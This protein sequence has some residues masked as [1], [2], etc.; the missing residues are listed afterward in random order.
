MLRSNNLAQLHSTRSWHPPTHSWHPF[1][2]KGWTWQPP[3]PK[4][5]VVDSYCPA[6]DLHIMPRSR[7]PHS[8][9][10][11]ARAGPRWPLQ[12][13][14]FWFK[15]D[16]KFSIAGLQF[17]ASFA[18]PGKNSA[19]R[20]LIASPSP[21]PALQ[22]P[23][24]SLHSQRPSSRAASFGRPPRAFASERQPSAPRRQ[25]FSSSEIL[26]THKIASLR[27]AARCCPACP[28]FSFSRPWPFAL[29]P[30][31]ELSIAT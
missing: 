26:I 10:E 21:G 31:A 13:L 18:S 1:P 20:S 5:G 16:F 17:A 3:S 23:R 19:R 9:T 8:K 12:P 11:R 25:V 7:K 22:V 27:N 4:I 14:A 6:D 30:P 15:N 24:P 28:N 29:G 2:T